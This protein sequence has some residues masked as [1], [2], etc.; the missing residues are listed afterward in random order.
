MHAAVVRCEAVDDPDVQTKSWI[1]QVRELA[2]DIEDWVDLFAHRVDAGSHD[3][4]AATA[5]RFSRWIRRG[6]DRLTTIPDRH[7]HGAHQLVASH[8]SWRVRRR[9]PVCDV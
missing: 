8:M 4:D 7:W 3:A 5:S 9:Q 1:G 6:I 2:Y